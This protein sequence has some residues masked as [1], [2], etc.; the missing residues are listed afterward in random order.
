MTKF[1]NL[2]DEEFSEL[3]RTFLDKLEDAL[4]EEKIDRD[5]AR[6]VLYRILYGVP[7]GPG[8]KVT[9]EVT[10]GTAVAPV[11]FLPF[12]EPKPEPP[13]QLPPDTLKAGTTIRLHASGIMRDR[14]GT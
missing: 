3:I 7:E 11:K 14:D 2:T 10:Y 6:R 5:T 12:V 4:R 13:M 8:L 1:E 9:K